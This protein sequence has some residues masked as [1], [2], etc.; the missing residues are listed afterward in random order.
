MAV[1]LFKTVEIGESTYRIKKFTAITGMQ[2]ARMILSKLTPLAPLLREAG[3]D[4]DAETLYA[5]LSQ[6]SKCLDTISDEELASLTKKCLLVC[7]K[8]MPHGYVNC[9][10]DAG[11]YALEGLEYDL[12]LTLRLIWEAIAWGAADFFDANGLGFFRSKTAALNRPKQ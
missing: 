11:N 8:K 4:L 1:D 10:D 3:N 2:I 5:N 9:I 12:L 6:L 7:A